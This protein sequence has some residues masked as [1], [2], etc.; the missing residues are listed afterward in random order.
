MR[1]H[2]ASL[3]ICTILY[4]TSAESFHIRS[5]HSKPPQ[6]PGWYAVQLRLMLGGYEQLT[7]KNNNKKA[8]TDPLPL[9]SHLFLETWRPLTHLS[10]RPCP[11][12]Y[13]APCFWSHLSVLTY[14]NSQNCQLYLVTLFRQL[15]SG[16]H[17]SFK[18]SHSPFIISITT[19]PEHCT[20]E[21]RQ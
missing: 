5:T 4:S 3:M 16:K 20:Y 12:W 9:D 1:T 21:N 10:K 13:W 6:R 17:Q 18:K 8:K 14:V 2:S 19:A 15:T 7:E 11:V